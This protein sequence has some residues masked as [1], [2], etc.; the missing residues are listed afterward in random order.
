MEPDRRHL[1]A[2]T[3]I[4]LLVVIAIIAILA[5]ILFPVLAAAKERAKSAT[6][7]SNLRQMG[8]AMNLYLADNDD[9]FHKGKGLTS[10]G[11][12][13]FGPHNDL[14][15]WQNWP[16]FY[17]PYVQ[18]VQVFDCPSSPIATDDL[19]K[20]NWA[21]NGNYGYNY[22]GLTGDEGMPPRIAS[23]LET[24]EV[25][26]FFDSATPQTVAG[27]NTWPYFLEQLGLNLNCGVNQQT[28]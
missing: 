26:A 21:N 19:K 4:E 23:T 2:F 3:L 14:N 1:K 15:G 28:S 18:N 9:T 5:A 22:S 24:A 10:S 7:I 12:Y 8:S 25:Y 6:C 16:Y 27:P 17:G 11:E 13:G 20:A